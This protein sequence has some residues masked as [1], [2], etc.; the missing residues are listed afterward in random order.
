MDA[1]VMV[2]HA[3]NT[4]RDALALCTQKLRQVNARIVGAVL[5]RVDRRAQGYYDSYSYS[6]YYREQEG[7]DEVT[8]RRS[9]ERPG[10][11]VQI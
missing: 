10:Q 11:N 6:Y 2:V 1:V 3:G 9:P 8:S 5:N 4:S 7:S